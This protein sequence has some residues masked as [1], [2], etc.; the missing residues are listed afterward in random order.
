MPSFRR[1]LEL[2][3]DVIETDVHATR[4]G[5]IVV[6]HDDGGMRAAG[7]PLRAE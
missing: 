5:H 7:V 1:A 6:S 4:D 3:V 2:G